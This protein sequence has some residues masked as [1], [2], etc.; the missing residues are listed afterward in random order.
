MSKHT[1]QKL[2]VLIRSIG[3]TVS[4]AYQ[5]SHIIRHQGSVGRDI[6][7]ELAQHQTDFRSFY[8]WEQHETRKSLISVFRFLH[9][10][11]EALDTSRSKN[12][13]DKHYKAVSWT[14]RPFQSDSKYS[15]FY[16]H[17][18]TA[19]DDKDFDVDM[20]NKQLHGLRDALLNL[21][22][23]RQ[24]IYEDISK[25]FASADDWP[26]ADD[27]KVGVHQGLDVGHANLDLIRA[28]E[29]LQGKLNCH[30]APWSA[31]YQEG[32]EEG[33]ESVSGS[34]SSGPGPDSDKKCPKCGRALVPRADPH[35]YPFHH[36][37]DHSVT[38]S[39][40]D[41]SIKLECLNCDKHPFPF[42]GPSSFSAPGS[43]PRP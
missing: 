20:A 18:S 6:R 10:F 34:S 12:P 19:S 2:D 31:V 5:K 28:C 40:S 30:P 32:K 7:S 29:E 21:K 36:S 16:E 13:S 35:P 4:N 24:D 38:S 43:G 3:E 26:L 15:H 8:E 42:H 22:K 17:D 27:F 33:S 41:D 25:T 37:Q 11:E 1:Q 14:K 23:K 39:P 9:E